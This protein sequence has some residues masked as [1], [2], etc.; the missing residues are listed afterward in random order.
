MALNWRDR[1]VWHPLGYGLTAAWMLLVVVV[2]EAETKHPFFDTIFLVPIG[3]WLIGL[4]I[5]RVLTRRRSR[6]SE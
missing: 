1:S 4:L 5:A 3:G 6:D 2:T